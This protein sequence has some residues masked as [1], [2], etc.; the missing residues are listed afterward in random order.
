MLQKIRTEDN[1]WA[2]QKLYYLFVVLAIVS[3]LFG[4]NLPIFSGDSTLYAHV[5]KNIALSGDYINLKVNGKDWLDKP[6]FHFWIHALF[7]K[8]FG[9]N[10]FSFR[11]PAFISFLIT[12]IYIYRY[13]QLKALSDRKSI[14]AVLIYATSLNVFR[15]NLDVRAEVFLSATIAISMYQAYLVVKTDKYRHLLLFSFFTGISC[16]IKGVY[17]LLPLFTYLFVEYYLQKKKISWRLFSVGVFTLLFIIPELYA[18]YL[19][20]DL[21]PE[22]EVF[23]KKNVSG[24]RFFLL[25]SQFGRFFNDGPIT[26]D[27]SGNILFFINILWSMFPWGAVVFF[28]I[29]SS[30]KRKDKKMRALVIVLIITLLMFSLSKFQLPYYLNIL[31]PLL[32][33]IL[34]DYLYEVKIG[35]KHLFV[36]ISQS[37]LIVCTISWLG[38]YFL[39]STGVLF[40]VVIVLGIAFVYFFWK[41]FILFLVSQGLVCCLFLVVVFYPKILGYNA[42]A[43]CSSMLNTTVDTCQITM[44]NRLNREFTLMLDDKFSTK[45]INA[46]EDFDVLKNGKLELFYATSRQ[47]AILNSSSIDFVVL[48]TFPDFRIT[49]LTIDFLNLNTRSETVSNMFLLEIVGEIT[50]LNEWEKRIIPGEIEFYID[51]DINPQVRIPER[52]VKRNQFSF[53]LSLTNEQPFSPNIEVS[54]DSMEGHIPSSIEVD[55]F[56]ASP[57]NE[58]MVLEI[59]RKDKKTKEWHGLRLDSTNI[60]TNQ[61]QK[62]FYDLEQYVETQ[63]INFI[64]VY[65]WNP[66]PEYEKKSLIDN[67]KIKFEK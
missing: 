61:W 1:A 43:K 3:L 35:I 31:F 32:S 58:L 49:K 67:L 22:K 2:T 16:M 36:A 50:G 41:D 25:D 40:W 19:Q 17:V 34:A 26:Q 62:L 7:F 18:L 52:Y 59:Q 54:L 23:G 20:F 46:V 38:Y 65:M 30:I 8:L 15:F 37:V 24:I 60:K 63:N 12:L 27:S 55:Y 14:L 47:L 45:K 44:F 39:D 29:Y 21:H 66:K 33:I 28:A 10:N 48:D 42:G 51:F 57:L 56:S 6:H 4:I 13:C 9:V 64:K 5:A 11:L 53:C